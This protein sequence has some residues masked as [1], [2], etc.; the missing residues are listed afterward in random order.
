M[1]KNAQIKKVPNTG[2]KKPAIVQPRGTT[3]KPKSGG[4][5]M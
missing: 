3:Q 5:K 4:R 2:T 1:V